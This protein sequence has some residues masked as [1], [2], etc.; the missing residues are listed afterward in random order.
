MPNKK[1]LFLLFPKEKK[2]PKKQKNK[3]KLHKTL[4]TDGNRSSLLGLERRVCARANLR[5]Q[6]AVPRRYIVLGATLAKPPQGL[7]STRHCVAQETASCT[8]HCQQEAPFSGV[9]AGQRQKKTGPVQ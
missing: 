1:L 2:P 8:D 4:S 3:K 7:A 5:K 6:Q 9:T